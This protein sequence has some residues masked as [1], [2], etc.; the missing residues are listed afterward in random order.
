MNRAA[1]LAAVL[2]GF[3]AY[4]AARFVMRQVDI[5]SWVH[6]WERV[7]VER[8]QAIRDSLLSEEGIVSDGG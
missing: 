3:A 8:R 7:P 6:A 1:Y 5:A 4:Y 2:V